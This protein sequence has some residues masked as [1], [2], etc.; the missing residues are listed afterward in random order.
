MSSP[1][2]TK[3][4]DSIQWHTG[5][6]MTAF[7][8]ESTHLVCLCFQLTI[9]ACDNGIPQRCSNTTCRIEVVT[10]PTTPPTFF[11]EPF[12]RTIPETTPLGTQI[13]TLSATNQSTLGQRV[14]EVETNSYPFTV[15]RFTGVVTLTYDNLRNGPERYSV[16]L[17]IYFSSDNA[18]KLT[19]LGVNYNYHIKSYS[20]SDSSCPT[21]F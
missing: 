20:F 4:I 2:S 17:I 6:D 21:L 14:F 3:K 13:L 10:C 16:S 19:L 9:Q 1:S 15:D 7:V 18:W 5:G 12:D 11:N 8:S